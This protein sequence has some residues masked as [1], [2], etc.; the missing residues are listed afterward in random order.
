MIDCP[1]DF[2]FRAC[3]LL[4][5][6]WN[7]WSALAYNVDSPWYTRI[8][9]Q[10]SGLGAGEWEVH[11]LC[12]YRIAVQQGMP[13][14]PSSHHL[15]RAHQSRPL[16]ELF[17]WKNPCCMGSWEYQRCHQWPLVIAQ[18]N[19]AKGAVM[20]KNCPWQLCQLIFQQRKKNV[21]FN[22]IELS[23]I[24][25][26]S[27]HDRCHRKGES[28]S[29]NNHERD[30]GLAYNGSPLFWERDIKL[31]ALKIPLTRRG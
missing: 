29:T 1:R 12:L 5:V 9:G 22:Y 2:C 24:K 11:I 31:G 14:C 27:H 10:H 21:L 25:V 17:V 3:L 7:V 30:L 23:L 18:F 15:A 20:V 26:P 8:T 28:T 4:S 13:V 19:V 16:A 6:Q